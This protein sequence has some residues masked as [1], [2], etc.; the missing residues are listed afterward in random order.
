MGKQLRERDWIGPSILITAGILLLLNNLGYLSWSVW[1]QISKFWPVL[2]I[3]AG[4]LMV[5]GGRRHGYFRWIIWLAILSVLFWAVSDYTKVGL[6][7]H[8]FDSKLGTVEKRYDTKTA[9]EEN[10][11]QS[12]E[13]SLYFDDAQVKLE[14]TENGLSVE[15]NSEIRDGSG[16]PQFDREWAGKDLKL[17]FRQRETPGSSWLG[18]RDN[19]YTLSLGRSRIPYGILMEMGSGEADVDLGPIRLENGDFRVGSGKLDGVFSERTPPSGSPL[20]LTVGSGVMDFSGLGYLKPAEVNATVGSGI[21]TI[22]LVGLEDKDA[23]KLKLSVGSGR[24]VIRLPKNISWRL[25]AV[26][27]SGNV[28]MNG[29]SLGHD[30]MFQA[31]EKKNGTGSGVD[32]D[33]NVGSGTVELVAE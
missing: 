16:E 30:N 4:L 12:V 26:I 5:I 20:T 24:A 17:G 28:L 19:S 6:D 7:L 18:R 3:M 14:N 1:G 2:L 23:C 9:G 21:A 25:N 10:N 27:G 13:L 11:A 32:I 29:K 22:G 31:S 8:A 15:M 33:L